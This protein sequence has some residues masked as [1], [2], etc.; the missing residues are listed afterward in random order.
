MSIPQSSLLQP[1]R[2]P[3]PLSAHAEGNLH[4]GRKEG[5]DRMNIR[6]SNGV[7]IQNDFEVK[8]GA[9]LIIGNDNN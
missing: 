2:S 7:T 5:A 1:L 4:Q 6:L 3:P 8:Q 9:Q